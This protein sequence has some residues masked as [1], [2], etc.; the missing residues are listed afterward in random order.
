MNRSCWTVVQ[1][2]IA[3]F[4]L[5]ALSI[6]Y[7]GGSLARVEGPEPGTYSGK[8]VREQR[9]R[10]H[11]ES[12]QLLDSVRQSVKSR[13]RTLEEEAKK[14]GE[15]Y[16][17]LHRIRFRQMGDQVE[18]RR[19]ILLRKVEGWSQAGKKEILALP[20]EEINGTISEATAIA[21]YYGLDTVKLTRMYELGKKV[22]RSSMFELPENTHPDDDYSYERMKKTALEN[23]AENLKPGF[24]KGLEVLMGQYFTSAEKREIEI[25]EF[26]AK[27]QEYRVLLFKRITLAYIKALLLSGE[28]LPPCDVRSA[29]HQTVTINGQSFPTFNCPDPSLDYMRRYV[30]AIRQLQSAETD[31]FIAHSRMVIAEQQLVVDMASALPLVG[32]AIDWYTLLY[33]IYAKENLTGHCMSRADYVIQFF[34]AVIPFMGPKMIEGAIARNPE[35]AQRL[36]VNLDEIFTAVTEMAGYSNLRRTGGRMLGSAASATGLSLSGSPMFASLAERWGVTPEQLEQFARNVQAA[37]KKAERREKQAATKALQEAQTAASREAKAKMAKIMVSTIDDANAQTQ[38]LRQLKR[39]A[40]EIFERALKDAEDIF[41][42]NLKAMQKSQADAIAN[43]NMVDTHVE[44]IMNYMRRSAQGLEGA[45]AEKMVLIYRHVNP[46]ATELIRQGFFTKGMDIKGKSADWGVHRGFVPI[47]QQFS[48]LNNPGK[49]TLSAEE[50][51]Y[52]EKFQ[53]KV[54]DFLGEKKGDASKYTVDLVVGGKPVMVVKD[55]KTGREITAF[56][57]PSTGRYLDENKI[58]FPEGAIDASQKRPLK[59]MAV[60]DE[61]GN[62]QA[63]TADYDFLAMGLGSEVGNPGYDDLTGFISQKQQDILADINHAIQ[64]K[65]GYKGNVS[66]HGPEVQYPDSPGAF[67]DPLVTTMDLEYGVLTIP[68]CDEACMRKWCVTSKQC[69][70]FG[71]P[72][73]EIC[74][75]KAPSPPCIPTDPDRLL[76]D[77][78]HLKRLEGYNLF[79]NSSWS[80]GDYNVLGGWNMV[81]FMDT[82]QAPGLFDTSIRVAR[83]LSGYITRT[84]ATTQTRIYGTL[85]QGLQAMTECPYGKRESDHIEAMP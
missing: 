75:S 14:E 25:A 42:N 10:Q 19:Q 61:A 49:G 16:M 31:T 59:V 39:E 65:T 20:A 84:R 81:S 62:P 47:E 60:P 46:D 4:L 11:E 38:A 1:K 8:D 54:T 40:P 23:A 12:L 71:F 5:L 6:G 67:Q 76:K 21:D 33:G 58:P 7:A 30:N 26:V 44:E 55:V 57:D 72:S 28:P 83:D 77:Y 53:K 2:I 63:L 34:A 70:Q 13:R 69:T 15:D 64:E 36:I 37:V 35:L 74:D 52:L 24:I 41:R 50:T 48:K 3:V 79:P 82:P 27:K 17:S 56:F 29:P 9:K 45:E 43:S 78:M 32:D 85:L 22:I 51:A 80:W 18:S 73:V 68:K 66:H